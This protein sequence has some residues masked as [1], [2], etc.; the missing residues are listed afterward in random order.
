LSIRAMRT[1]IAAIAQP[2]FLAAHQSNVCDVYHNG[3]NLFAGKYTVLSGL[4]NIGRHPTK[5]GC[6]ARSTSKILSRLPDRLSAQLFAGAKSCHL[7]A[8]EKRP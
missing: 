6:M 2:D 5:S 1:S 3:L 7:D 4:Q 8:G